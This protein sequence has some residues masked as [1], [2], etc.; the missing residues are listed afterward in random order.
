[1]KL[2]VRLESLQLPPRRGIQ[3]ASRI[4]AAG[5]QVDAAGDLTPAQ[6]S[7]TGRREFRNL[8][9]SFD[10]DLAALG[11]PLRRGLDVAENLQPRLEH[12]RQVMS[13]AYELGTRTVVVELPAI[14]AEPKEP[15]AGPAF[16]AGGLIL[17]SAPMA[18]DPAKLLR[19]S[20]LDLGAHGNRVGVTLALE[21]G[22]DPA[23][24]VAAY[25]ARFDS[26]ALGVAY[27]PANML[28]NG[29]DPIKSIAPLHARITH[30]LARD[31]RRSGAS[32]LSAEVPLGAGDIDW[33]TLVAV[34]DTV[35]YRGPMVVRREGG[36]DR[37]IDVT[38]GLA[39]LRLFVRPN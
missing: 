3:E 24:T 4:G 8:L 37:L 2:A 23:E 11:C 31:A 30:V 18:A 9:R 6:F 1:M 33:M 13:L 34:L 25:L 5:V 20:L 36:N 38:N 21:I 14:P 26:G 27:D 39:F 32:R 17:G 7:A 28:M 29:H 19:E 10:L 35:G 16:S 15:D 12:V 22:V